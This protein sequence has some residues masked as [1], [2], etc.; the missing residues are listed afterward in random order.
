MRLRFELLDLC[1]LYKLDNYWEGKPRAAR[2]ALSTD[3]RC[4]GPERKILAVLFL[5][6]YRIDNYLLLIQWLRNCKDFNIN[7][8]ISPTPGVI[9]TIAQLQSIIAYVSF[10]S[11]FCCSFSLSPTF[12]VGWHPKFPLANFRMKLPYEHIYSL[13]VERGGRA[14]K[15]NRLFRPISY[16]IREISPC[17]LS[18]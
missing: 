13:P 2:F 14:E 9:T 1:A 5:A 16:P 10:L 11:Y 4:T 12:Q 7:Y 8:S 6:G 3:V 17:P 15:R 18:K